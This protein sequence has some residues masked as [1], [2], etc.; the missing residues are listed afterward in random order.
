MD[1]LQVS[2][3]KRN[4]DKLKAC[5]K[6]IGNS[7]VVTKDIRLMFPERY[8]TRNLASLGSLVKVLSIY[9]IID[10]DNN[11][12]VVIAPIVQEI[13]PF[14]IKDISVDN[15]LYKELIFRENDVFMPNTRLVKADSFLYDMFDEFYTKGNIPWYLNYNDMANLLLETKKYADSNIGKNPLAMEIITSVIA[16]DENDKRTFFRQT[17]KSKTDIEK[18]PTYVGLNNIYFSLETTDAKLVGGYFGYSITTAI[19]DQ[20]KSTSEVAKVLRA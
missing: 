20:E 19:V 3:L 17:L 4:P 1:V 16:R 18:R 14:T 11:Y 12:A 13:T 2:K 5:F 7:I 8:L 6:T 9:A 15:I 10:D